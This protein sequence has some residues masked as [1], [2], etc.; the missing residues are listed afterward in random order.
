[1]AARRL[2]TMSGGWDH[3]TR[4]ISGYHVRWLAA[5]GGLADLKTVFDG[6]VSRIE[7]H[8][9]LKTQIDLFR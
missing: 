8:L 5:S 6:G 2:L 1:V 9:P 7:N 4:K 3:D